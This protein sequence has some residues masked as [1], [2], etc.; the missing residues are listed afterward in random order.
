[1]IKKSRRIFRLN[2]AY[3]YFDRL[4]DFASNK[5]EKISKS[6]KNTIGSKSSLLVKRPIELNSYQSTEII[7]KEY[8]YFFRTSDGEKTYLGGYA[9]ELIGCPQVL[10][11]NS[12]VDGSFYHEVREQNFEFK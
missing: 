9:T 10:C 4:P 11:I 7:F 12:Y 2:I 3:L 5:F 8:F 1:M 6:E